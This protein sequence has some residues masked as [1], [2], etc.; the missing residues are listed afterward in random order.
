MLLSRLS[1]VESKKALD[2]I[3]D[4]KCLIDTLNAYSFVLAQK[5]SQ[6]AEAIN[7]CDYLLPDGA[8]I[9][10]ACRWLKGRCVPK[11]R[12]AGWDL[13]SYD[14]RRQEE[15]AQKTGG[16]R[17]IL[18]VGSS[19]A[20]LHLIQERVKADYP[21]LDTLIYSPP[22]KKTFSEDDSRAIVE[23]INK[24]HPDLLWIGMTAPKQEIW[25]W[26]HWQQLDI[27]CH[28]GAIGAVFDFYAGTVKRAPLWMQRHAL[29]WLYRWVQEPKR[30]WRRYMIGNPLFAWY[31]LKE[32]TT[33]RSG[34]LLY[35]SNPAKTTQKD[36]Q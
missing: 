19:E 7:S 24:T 3:P 36:E 31:I 34:M 23:Y 11:E 26:Q 18:F 8:S 29:E 6:Y 30:L 20:V 35:H 21:H 5:D 25:L 1:F 12:I 17:K 15:V 33:N 28:V 9:V 16:R 32:K 10:L 14:M 27:D 4:G 13:F 2:G 22:Y